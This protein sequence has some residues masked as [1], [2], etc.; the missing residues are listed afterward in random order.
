MNKIEK[1]DPLRVSFPLLEKEAE[2]EPGQTVA[3]ACAAIGRPLQLICGGKGTCGKC[4]LFVETDGR[5]REIL[6]CQEPAVSGM[7]IF[8]NLPEDRK[9]HILTDSLAASAGFQPRLR[10]ILVRRD[11]FP[12]LLCSGLWRL[13]QNTADLPDVEPN[14][15]RL[16]ELADLFRDTDIREYTLTLDGDRL[17]ALEAGDTRATLYGLAIDLGTTTVAAYAYNVA[18][19]E[20]IG[21]R[22]AL[23]RQSALGADVIS[24][25]QAAS[26]PGG[27]ER[28]QKAATDT[29]NGL[30]ETFH[31]DFG[32]APEQIYTCI[33]CGNSAMQHLL[34]GL[35][36]KSL[37]HAPFHCVTLDGL[38]VEARE[39]GLRIR[40][41]GLVRFL[42]LI[43][44]FVGA[45]TLA[46]A[47]ALNL[48]NEPRNKLLIDIG[49][50]CELLVGNGQRMLA[51]SAAAGPAFEGA[52]IACG[53]NALAGA[54]RTVTLSPA[55]V[56]WEAI[57]NERP[58]GLCGSGLVD[59]LAQMARLG[60]V[61]PKGRLALREEYLALGGQPALA[62][63]LTLLDLNETAERV[64]ILAQPEETG[65]GKPVYL[66]QKDVR[67]LQLAKGAIHTAYSILLERYGIKGEELDEIIVCGAFGTYLNKEHAQALGIIPN[68]PGVPVRAA[69]NAAGAGV[70]TCLLS[71]EKQRAALELPARIE[72]IELATEEAFSRIFMR[73]LDFT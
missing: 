31:K 27:R 6:A 60:L 41:A 46:C 52:E 22:A 33:I 72:H 37:G 18:S 71:A 62:E 30:I 69:G 73:S 47:L 15:E 56:R 50:N 4:A 54:I 28:L 8:L 21:A 67:A 55:G 3:Q 14:L 63:R 51:A 26:K 65:H 2:L 42:P 19:G 12:P 70:Q 1:S 35:P 49:T 64:F 43:G 45:D 61:S 32:I 11:D 36:P 48:E 9:A 38:N 57:G 29:I 7:K 24:R 10:K 34:F 58:I 16:R 68:F 20:Q 13:V 53:M 40:P 44:G 23:N 25:I 59:T 5:M 17:T 66:S 39:I